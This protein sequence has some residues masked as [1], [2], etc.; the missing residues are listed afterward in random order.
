MAFCLRRFRPMAISSYPLA[1]NVLAPFWSGTASLAFKKNYNNN[2]IL[3]LTVLSDMILFYSASWRAVRFFLHLTA[4]LN[5]LPP[6]WHLIG[7]VCHHADSKQWTGATMRRRCCCHLPLW[8]FF[9]PHN[10]ALLLVFLP[11]SWI[12]APSAF[13]PG[14]SYSFITPGYLPF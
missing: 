9:P 14:H 4:T 8:R 3:H 5:F 1:R 12:S 2:N 7:A 11:G 13:M 10:I 6:P